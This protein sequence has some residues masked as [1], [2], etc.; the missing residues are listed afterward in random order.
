MSGIIYKE[1]SYSLGL[2]NG[3]NDSRPLFLVREDGESEEV[4]RQRGG[5]ARDRPRWG[6][7]CGQRIGRDLMVFGHAMTALFVVWLIM[8]VC[9]FSMLKDE[10]SKECPKAY[11]F[12]LGS[13]SV[14]SCGR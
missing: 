3:V 4:D 1:C 6:R 14:V 8:S 13:N 10:I 12:A 7:G 11:L 2:H 9:A 5:D